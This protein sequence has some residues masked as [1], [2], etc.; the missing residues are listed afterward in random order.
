[1]GA[2]RGGQC[3]RAETLLGLSSALPDHFLAVWPWASCLPLC[4]SSTI[5]KLGAINLILTVV[6]KIQ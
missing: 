4:A 1:M 6:V 5:C 2:E 3:L